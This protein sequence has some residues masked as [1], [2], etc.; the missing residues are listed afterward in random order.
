MH[1]SHLLGVLCAVVCSFVN[2]S[3]FAAT[4][5]V[6]WTGHVTSITSFKQGAVPAGITQGSQITGSLIF[7]S[8]QYNS[9]SKILGN[10]S[11]GEKYRYTTGLNQTITSEGWEWQISGA[12]VSLQHIF[13]SDRQAFDVYSTSDNYYYNLFPN[14]VGRFEYGF[15]LFDGNDPLQLFNSYEIYNLTLA[16]DEITRANGFLTSRHW[17]QN[18]DID[19]GYY[20][21][22]DIDG[23]SLSPVPLPPT[24][25]LFGSGLLGLIGVA[26]RK[27]AA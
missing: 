14:F 15:A 26:K 23:V 10:F 11:S 18:G 1:K 3:S 24:L 19:D 9:R 2:T 6:Y 12:D 16:L 4:I 25:W 21:T 20:M 7:E 22:F 5:S 17:D 27:N 13:S 8:T